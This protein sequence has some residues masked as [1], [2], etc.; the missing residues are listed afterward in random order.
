MARLTGRDILRYQSRE[1]PRATVRRYYLAWRKVQGCARFN[2][3]A[4]RDV[5][6]AILFHRNRAGRRP[7]GAV[8]VYFVG[9]IRLDHATA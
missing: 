2:W 7:I 4:G 5:A 6:A 3:K 9:A 8:A 1:M